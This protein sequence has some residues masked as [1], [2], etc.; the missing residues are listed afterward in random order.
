METKIQKW[1]NSLGVRLPK[2]ITEDQAL[3]AGSFVTVTQVDKKIIVERVC[4][5][6]PDLKDLVGQITSKNLHTEVDW[7]KSVG[8]EI[9]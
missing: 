6:S 1:G 8:N 3:Q 9:W 7:G 2:S 4:H 5:K